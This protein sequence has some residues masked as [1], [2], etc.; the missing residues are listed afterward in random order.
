MTDAIVEGGCLCGS[1]RY[2]VSGEPLA[3]TL[4]HCRSCRM[5]SAAPSV[6]WVVF[7]RDDFAFI[8]GEPTRFR[9]SPAVVRT[10][11]GTCGTPLTYQHESR[12]DAVDITTITLDN[13]DDFAPTKEIWTGEKVAWE[14]VNEAIAQYPE[15]SVGNADTS[16]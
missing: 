6:A 1:V 8:T 7:G 14:R 4:C 9:S 5:A 2:R 11:C 10:F 13:P 15:S 16:S 3:R 12:P